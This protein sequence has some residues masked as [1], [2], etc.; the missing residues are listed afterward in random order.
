MG[1]AH[2]CQHLMWQHCVHSGVRS[3]KQNVVWRSIAATE[4]RTGLSGILQ[5]V[6]P[7][8]GLNSCSCC[9]AL[10]H[11]RNLSRDR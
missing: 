4:L 9:M 3:C 2:P 1:S 6:L 8:R 5:L 7:L 10:Q 11:A